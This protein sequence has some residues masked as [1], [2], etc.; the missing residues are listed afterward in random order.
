VGSRLKVFGKQDAWQSTVGQRQ[1]RAYLIILEGIF[2][3]GLMVQLT[4]PRTD[5]GHAKTKPCGLSPWHEQAIP[6]ALHVNSSGDTSTR[7][8][9]R[10][11]ILS[12]IFV[13]YRT[14]PEQAATGNRAH[15]ARV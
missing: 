14:E 3:N 8:V 11:T 6:N 7:Q 2:R 1:A 15:V 5:P 4:K 9:S 13:F 10:N 12:V